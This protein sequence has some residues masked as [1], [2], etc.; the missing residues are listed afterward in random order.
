[1]SSLSRIEELALLVAL[2]KRIGPRLKEAKD[3][4]CSRLVRDAERGCSDR[5]PIL[6][7][8]ERVG[9][10]GVSYTKAAPHILPERMADAIGCLSEMGLVDTVPKKG[11]ES[12][13]ALVGGK[14]VCTDTGEEVDWAV[15]EPSRPKSASVRDCEPEDVMTAFGSRLSGIDPAALLEG[16][17]RW[18]A[19]TSR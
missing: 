8:D 5:F 10:V 4:V 18:D 6:V 19:G 15:W 14:V 12:H 16:G 3:Y 1:M 11:W 7:G 17:S 9:E 2:D 13:F